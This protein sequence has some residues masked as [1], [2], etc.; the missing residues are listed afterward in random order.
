MKA[1]AVPF[2]N[3]KPLIYGIEDIRLE[4]P[5]KL[6]QLL[7]EEVIDVALLS[8]IEY[9]RKP[10]LYKFI[11][12]I[13][14]SSENSIDSVRLYY[15]RVP[16]RKVALDP[17]SLSAN[18]LA[19]VI[20]EK[21]YGIKPE[22]TF[23]SGDFPKNVDGAVVIGDASFDFSKLPFLD[24]SSEW[25]ALTGKPFVYA[26]WIHSRDVD[27]GPLLRAK[28]IGLANLES[29][30]EYEAKRL[31]MTKEFCLGYLRNINYELGSKELQGLEAFGEFSR[32]LGLA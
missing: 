27:V 15:S 21:K 17:A 19:Q 22:L 3:A 30:A 13:C 5:V 28:E 12:G 7:E 25:Y 8:S 6:R 18:C 10:S 11:Q 1:G 23:H 29:I 31:G 2:L 26:L 24:L 9:L 16:V 4:E 14:I 32:E 20:I